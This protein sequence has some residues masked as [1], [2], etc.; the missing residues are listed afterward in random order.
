VRPNPSLHPTF[1]SRLRR[2]S[3]AGELQRQAAI[4]GTADV[5]DG[6]HRK[7]V[8]VNFF[9]RDSA[10]R[11]VS[12][13]VAL[14]L[15]LLANSAMAQKAERPNVKVGDQWQFV[16]Y[17]TVPSTTPN[18]AWL[19]TSVTSK[20]IEGTEN[21]E[22]LLLT[23]EL[24]VLESPRSK[25]SNPKA[26]TFPLEVGKHWRYASDWVFK[27]KDS[28]GSTVVDVAVVGYEKVTVPAGEFDA[29]KLTSKGSLHGTS[30]IN[31]QYG[32]ETTETYWYAP[33]ARAIV[34]WV[35][36]NPYLGTSN[37]ELVAFQLRP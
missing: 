14:V 1:A 2:L 23:P 15:A 30:P 35:R 3:L 12:P 20:N 16:L 36:H 7:G 9:K 8:I 25:E 10:I 13:M 21:G 34:K 27:A 26:L 28:K 19:I 31:S 4:R 33:T 32:G 5:A 22:V 29:F 24:N 6:E 37:V 17:Y 18:R 11:R